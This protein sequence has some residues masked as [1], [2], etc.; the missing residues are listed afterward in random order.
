MEGEEIE[1]GH[2]GQ[3]RRERERERD[4][5]YPY[6]LVIYNYF[7]NMDITEILNEGHRDN[8]GKGR[9]KNVF[10]ILYLDLWWLYV[11]GLGNPLLYSSSEA[12][13]LFF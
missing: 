9:R 5:F 8:F 10:L 12:G 1:G 6:T 7:L 3:V 11:D 2:F 4:L 13:N